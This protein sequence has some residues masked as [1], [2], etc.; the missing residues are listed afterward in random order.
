MPTYTIDSQ[1]SKLVVTA[2]SSVHD[3][4]IVWRGISGTIDANVEE[5]QA[6]QASINVDMSTADAGDWLKNRKIR[7]DMDFDKHPTASFVLNQISEI[8]R[9]GGKVS[10]TISGRLSWRGKTIDITATGD[11]TLT[12]DELQASGSFEIDMTRLGVRPPKVLMIKVDDV[13][14][15]R[16]KL[17]ALAR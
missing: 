15:C 1:T 12:D 9:S 17:T 13:V 4:E 6:T 11:G 3:S 8:R 16:I 5:M 10:A 14:S 2:R 7:K